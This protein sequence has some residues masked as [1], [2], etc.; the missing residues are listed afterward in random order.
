MVTQMWPTLYKMVR[1]YCDSSYLSLQQVFLMIDG[2]IW[3][4]DIGIFR[5]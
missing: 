5:S 4:G 1:K 2:F 3:E